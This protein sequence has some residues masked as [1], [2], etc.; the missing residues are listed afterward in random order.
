MDGES[1]S[2]AESG[3]VRRRQR[4]QTEGPSRGDR[5][6]GT[7]GGAGSGAGNGAGSEAGSGPSSSAL[8]WLTA[9]GEPGLAI[10]PHLP[11]PFPAPAG[12]LKRKP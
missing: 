12:C 8:R 4:E 3:A 2:R 11:T 1:G 10:P 6:Q 7:G 5:Q 9:D